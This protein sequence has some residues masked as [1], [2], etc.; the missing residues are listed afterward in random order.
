M[1][2]RQSLITRD[3]VCIPAFDASDPLES[4]EKS[5]FD[6][7]IWEIMN[8]SVTK[9]EGEFA[10]WVVWVVMGGGFI[11]A[12]L[13]IWI[14]MRQGLPAQTIA[15]IEYTL[16]TI[17]MLGNALCY[18]AQDRY[19]RKIER[20]RMAYEFFV[21]GAYGPTKIQ[22]TYK[23]LTEHF[24]DDDRRIHKLMQIFS[25]GGIF[26]LSI[27]GGFIIIYLYQIYF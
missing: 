25:Y 3:V 13:T 8:T 18:A 9:N 15:R 24:T 5:A 19:A 20:Y 2:R 6:D 12:P 14:A 23:Y 4:L 22:K 11:I 7:S 21:P 10:G 1:T 17:G 16:F 26:F 27:L